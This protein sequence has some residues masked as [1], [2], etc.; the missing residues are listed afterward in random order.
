M[1]TSFIPD[2]KDEP[3]GPHVRNTFDLWL[4]ESD[5]PT[6]LLLYV[7]GGGFTRGDKNSFSMPLKVECLSHG[8]AFGAA[9]YRLATTAPYPA[10]MHDSARAV[11]H[12]RHHAA[13]YSIALPDLPQFRGLW[14][15]LP[16]VAKRRTGITCLF[17]D[18]R[19]G[20]DEAQ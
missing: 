9:N 19:G 14:Q 3:Y 12:I 16:E 15:R 20:V 7:H 1:L 6:P 8:I 18:T 5:K 13:R 10:P 11:Q 17:V 2:V 4:P